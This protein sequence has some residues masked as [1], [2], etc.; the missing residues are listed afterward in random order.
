M[1]RNGHG[2]PHTPGP[3]PCAPCSA[4]SWAIR[5]V[6][7]SVRPPLDARERGCFGRCKVHLLLASC[8]EKPTM[9]EGNR[10]LAIPRLQSQPTMTRPYL[11]GF[12]SKHECKYIDVYIYICIYS[13]YIY[14]SIQ[15]Y[16]Y[17]YI[18]THIYIY[19]YIWPRRNPRALLSYLSSWLGRG[20]LVSIAPGRAMAQT[21][22]DALEACRGSG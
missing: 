6:L 5:S 21:Q 10:C 9:L 16:I 22:W 12:Q 13:L 15:L 2:S 20:A 8:L 1:R 19:R 3:L 4:R 11:P 7:P 14:T 17:A 18:Y